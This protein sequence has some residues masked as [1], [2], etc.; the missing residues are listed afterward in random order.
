MD[1]ISRILIVDDDPN[2]RK[3]MGDILIAKGFESIPAGTGKQAIQLA[4][5]QDIAAALID[6]RLE[7]MSGLEVLKTIRAHSPTTECILLTGHTSEES[8]IEAVN[9]GAY[10]YFQKTIDVDHLLLTVRRAVEKRQA[11]RAL[12]ENQ[13][14]LAV[15]MS[16]LPGIAYRC[17]NDPQWTMQFIS[18]G[19]LE[20]TGYTSA[21]L[22]NNQL[23]AFVNLIHPDDRGMVRDAIERSIMDRTPYRLNYRI[24]TVNGREKWV[25]E[26]GRPI[27]APDGSLLAL[28][29][30]ISD[31]TERTHAEEALRNSEERYRM[32][33]ENMSE[34]IWLMDRNM[35]TIYVSPSV[36]RLRGYTL[37]ELMKLPIEKQLTPASRPIARQAMEHFLAAG[38]LGRNDPPA[39]IT[40]ELEFYKKDGSTFWSENTY[41]LIYN[42]MGIPEAILGIGRDISERKKSEEVQRHHLAELEVLY[43]NSMN[44]NR[45]MEPGQVAR[46]MIRTLGQKLDWNHAAIRIYHPE[47]DRIE[48]VAFGRPGYSEER[49]QAEIKRLNKLMVDS[50]KGLSGWV[51]RNGQPLRVGDVRSDERYFES[52]PGIRSGVYIPIQVGK[53]V[54][55]SIAVESELEDAFSEAD[56]RLLTILASQSASAFEN[57]RLFQELQSELEERKR[58]EAELEKYRAHL[59]KLVEERTEALKQREEHYRMLFTSMQEGYVLHEAI[60]DNTKKVTDFRVTE[61][62]PAAIQ[63]SGMRAEEYVGHTIQEINGQ[64]GPATIRLFK[65]TLTGKQPIRTEYESNGKYLESHI[66]SPA[67]G[68][69]ANI[70]IDISQRKQAENLLRESEASV[71]LIMDMMP[72]A[73]LIV[74]MS[75][76]IVSANAQTE[77]L[78]QYPMA[79]LIG[80][81]IETLVPASFFGTKR[82]EENETVKPY[83]RRL[84]AL[85]DL[86]AVRKNGNTFPVM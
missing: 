14:Q 22:T 69:V 37:D 13:R 34:T 7:D 60:R 24:L 68:R 40:L 4:S 84:G 3:T 36:T 85:L 81:S 6:L 16:N 21:E 43:Q 53:R 18:E 46:A 57:A 25:W 82:R 41:N 27:Y 33:A 77:S 10:S 83:P 62:N 42:E 50:S 80:Q 63:L 70:L 23:I 19:C 61:A 30:F 45:Q 79:Q 38:E 55:G 74:D 59:E 44:I 54:I 86:T 73:I 58:A 9:L 71:R 5:T 35:N 11:V 75:G 28:E 66:F 72:E 26:Q 48:V 49:I 29:G 17:L 52:F 39:S 64:T 65:K 67:H 56:Q 31:V 47:S 20:L 2:L 1:E 15:L 32:L 12:A 76:N 8:A 51:I 78:F